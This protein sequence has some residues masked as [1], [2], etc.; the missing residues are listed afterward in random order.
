MPPT[1]KTPAPPAATA[2][3][4]LAEPR[5]NPDETVTLSVVGVGSEWRVY[6]SKVE[7]RVMLKTRDGERQVVEYPWDEWANAAR[8]V[9]SC[10]NREYVRAG[11]QPS[12]TPIYCGDCGDRA[13]RLENGRASCPVHGSAS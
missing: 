2:P 7:H 10:V 8:Y 13:T 6:S 1:A 11:T 4:N 3:L 9:I 12:Q 5:P